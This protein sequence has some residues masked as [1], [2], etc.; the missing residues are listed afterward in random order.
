MAHPGAE[1]L[2]NVVGQ[3]IRSATTAGYRAPTAAEIIKFGEFLGLQFPEDA[4]LL[5]VAEQAISSPLP[6]GW[7]EHVDSSSGRV[8]YYHRATDV[9]QV[10]HPADV[11][12]KQMIREAQERKRRV[13]ERKKMVIKQQQ[14]KS[15]VQVRKDTAKSLKYFKSFTKPKSAMQRVESTSHIPPT[16]EE[17]KDMAEYLNI[18]VDTELHLLWIALDTIMEPLPS[19]WEEY[20]DQHGAFYYDRKN[21]ISTRSHPSDD[22]A[23]EKVA[24]IRSLVQNGVSPGDEYYEKITEALSS[25]PY[26]KMTGLNGDTYFYDFKYGVRR[27]DLSN[28]SAQ[29]A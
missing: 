2:Q 12:F 24:K 27:A 17:V 23:F 16:P 26:L 11:V 8:F 28:N 19:N 7:T 15:K 25:S 5:W 4:S 20:Q 6:P 29:A 21:H 14:K 10:E 22:A 9:S 18:N 1:N 13:V 3:K